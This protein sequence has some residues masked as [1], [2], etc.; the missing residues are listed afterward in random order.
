[1]LRLVGSSYF[2]IIDTPR[3]NTICLP[4]DKTK[5]DKYDKVDISKDYDAIIAGWGYTS[6]HGHFGNYSKF[7]CTS[8]CL[9]VSIIH[10]LKISYYLFEIVGPTADTLQKLRVKVI[11]HEKCAANMAGY[12]E[13]YVHKGIHPEKTICAGGEYGEFF[14]IF[15]SI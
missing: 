15:Y 9:N 11:P 10:T 6:K 1:M 14:G 12:A 13:H 3:V 2:F 7:L 5:N 4:L 8:N